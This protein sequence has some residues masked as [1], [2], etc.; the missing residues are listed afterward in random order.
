MIRVLVVDDDAQVRAGLRT[1]LG[2]A[3]DVLVVG[4]AADG[5][6]ALDLTARDLPDVV[7]MDVRMPRMDGVRATIRLRERGTPSRILILTTFDTD[8]LVLAA[9]RAG[10]NGFLLKDTVPE[11][12]VAAVR[13]VAAG[14]PALSPS[15][16]NRVIAA[17]IRPN[18]RQQAARALLA[19]LTDRER[20]V[21]LSISDGLTNQ[22]IARALHMGVATVKTHVGNVFVKFGAT[23]RVQVARRVHDAEL[24]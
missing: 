23:N 21:A 8:E 9:L 18:T 14:E 10:A 1:V 11:D 2:G 24:L 4:E 19:S 3:S 6:E 7:L 20:A 13:R 15:V 17:A 12:V 22:E 16:T 5:Q